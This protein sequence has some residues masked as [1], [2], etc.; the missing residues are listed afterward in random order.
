MI[1]TL[2]DAALDH[3]AVRGAVE[4]IVDDAVEEDF[5]GAVEDIVDDAVEEDFDGAVVDDNLTMQQAFLGRPKTHK[6]KL[7]DQ[8]NGA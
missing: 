8:P 6:F 2:R 3:D 4:D 7:D 1:D 5:D